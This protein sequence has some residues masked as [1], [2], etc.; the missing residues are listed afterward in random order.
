MW[1]GAVRIIELRWEHADWESSTPAFQ[2]WDDPFNDGQ[3]IDWAD[4]ICWMA[5]PEAPPQEKIDELIDRLREN[6]EKKDAVVPSLEYF[7]TK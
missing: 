5:L 1:D 7:L 2:Y 3:E 6:Q 4:I